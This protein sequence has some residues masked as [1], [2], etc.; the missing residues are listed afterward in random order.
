[1]TGFT[2]ASLDD[3]ARRRLSFCLF[4]A[5]REPEG[6]IDAIGQY[7]SLVR[8]PTARHLPASVAG[9][10]LQD[11]G[12]LLQPMNNRMV[13]PN[14]RLERGEIEQGVDNLSLF[15]EAMPQWPV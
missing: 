12:G 13:A 5:A 8:K 3:V 6:R 4:A 2:Y 14:E 7:L 11:F 15:A 9:D 1:M 10:R